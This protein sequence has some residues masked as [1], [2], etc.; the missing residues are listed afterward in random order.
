MDKNELR[1]NLFKSEM[2]HAGQHQLQR[3]STMKVVLAISG[4]ILAIIGFDN[5]I[6]SGDWPYGLIIVLLAFMGGLFSVKQQ[7]RYTYH[8]EKARS[9]L[10]ELE[11]EFPEIN[12]DSYIKHALSVVQNRFPRVSKVSLKEFWLMIYFIVG[13]TGVAIVTIALLSCP[14]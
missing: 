10:K 2:E 14:D 9:I 8:R 6:S 12:E 4:A 7:E 5:D 3:S 11:S 13:V 1:W